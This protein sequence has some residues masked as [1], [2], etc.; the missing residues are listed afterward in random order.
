MLGALAAAPF[1]GEALGLSIGIASGGPDSS[2][3]AV[4]AAADA[5]MYRAKRSG[6]RRYTLA[7]DVE[8]DI[9][10]MAAAGPPSPGE[11]AV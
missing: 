10:G 11:S 7:T 4:F 5:A 2:G 1:Q 8:G 3:A 6:G 9:P